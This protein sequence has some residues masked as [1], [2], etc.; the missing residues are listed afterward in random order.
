MSP[1]PPVT[2]T[3]LGRPD[4]RVKVGIADTISFDIV[5]CRSRGYLRKRVSTN[6][7]QVISSQLPP[8][9]LASGD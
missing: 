6:S 1:A 3:V 7:P 4:G 5:G 2:M 8:H 9:A